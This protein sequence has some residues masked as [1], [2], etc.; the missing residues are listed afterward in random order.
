MDEDIPATLLIELDSKQWIICSSQMA[1]S[2]G[3]GPNFQP[4]FRML[5]CR[6]LFVLID[7]LSTNETDN[8]QTSRQLMLGFILR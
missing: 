8:C 2:V 3:I 1:L 7:I 5:D 4:Y 6:S